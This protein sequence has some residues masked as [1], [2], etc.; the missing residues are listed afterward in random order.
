MKSVLVFLATI[1]ILGGCGS[2][3]VTEERWSAGGTDWNRGYGYN[4]TGVNS[5]KRFMQL[6]RLSD[7]AVAIFGKPDDG[8][9]HADSQTRHFG[10]QTPYGVEHNTD[11]N[12][13]ERTVYTWGRRLP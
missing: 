5:A 13:R 4:Q 12:A 2:I 1:I 8:Y 10:V 3:T 6:P 9:H 11:Y 7:L